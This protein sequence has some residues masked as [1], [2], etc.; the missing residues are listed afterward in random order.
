MVMA[1]IN[2]TRPR[3]IADDS[4][5]TVEHKPA[6]HQSIEPNIN[7]DNGIVLNSVIATILCL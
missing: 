6:N 1:N 7:I 3:R 5:N 2:Q 4:T